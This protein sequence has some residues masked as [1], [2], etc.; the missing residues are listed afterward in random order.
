MESDFWNR[1]PNGEPLVRD[2]AV[3]AAM[4]SVPRAAFLPVALRAQAQ[5]DRALPI[6][7]GVTISQPS[8]V[9]Q[10][11]VALRLTGKERVLE[12]GC[13]SGYFAALLSRLSGEVH[14]V[15]I[16]HPLAE[17]ARRRLKELGCDR[18]TVYV[19]D[20]SVG[21]PSLAPF[22]CIVLSAAPERIPESLVA[23]LA[24]GGRMILPLGA[25]GEDQS[26][27]LVEKRPDGVA[28]TRDLMPVRF[29]PMTGAAG[30]GDSERD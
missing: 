1:G 14:T 26:L 5:E 23:Q 8:L 25:N 13:G 7:H 17:A 2:A 11:L 18:V 9:A 10:M 28:V 20:G 16:I 21:L 30:A 24:R 15:E 27:V 29:V 3:I 22:D 12:I 6:G 4:R 19:G